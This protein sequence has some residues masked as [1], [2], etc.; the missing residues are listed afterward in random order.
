MT[1]FSCPK[2]DIFPHIAESLMTFRS[3]ENRYHSSDF[4]GS[5]CLYDRERAPVFLLSKSIYSTL[6]NIPH[7]CKRIKPG[8][9]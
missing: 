5:A 2:T 1:F 3:P 7:R 9:S 6:K 4:F 8:C